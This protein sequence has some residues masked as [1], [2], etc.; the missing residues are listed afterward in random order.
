MLV[1]LDAE[2]EGDT[3]H[4]CGILPSWPIIFICHESNDMK[5]G[6]KRPRCPMFYIL[7]RQK[8]D[9]RRLST[10]ESRLPAACCQM[11]YTSTPIPRFHSR[12]AMTIYNKKLTVMRAIINVAIWVIIN[13][14]FPAFQVR[15]F[16][17][18]VIALHAATRGAHSALQHTGQTRRQ[19]SRRWPLFVTQ[20]NVQKTTRDQVGP[21]RRQLRLNE[22]LAKLRLRPSISI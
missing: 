8:V 21:T 6:I 9:L 16:P 22:L 20:S 19:V 1:G 7:Y 13:L 2:G 5:F 3:K 17:E 12:P 15:W 10:S 4:E 18:S 11:I 14:C